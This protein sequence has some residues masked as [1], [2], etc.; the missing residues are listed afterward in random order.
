MNLRLPFTLLAL[1]AL[2]AFAGEPGPGPSDSAKA[3]L[4]STTGWSKDAF[5]PSPKSGKDILIPPPPQVRWILGG[6]V[7]LRHIGEIDFDSGV[8]P[9]TI[10]QLFAAGNTPVPGIGAP[11]G[12]VPRVYDNGY[13]GPDSRTPQIGRTTDY[14]YQD[15]GQIQADS[16]A[17]TATGGERREVTRTAG[18]TPA[19]WNE[20][21]EWNFSPYLKLSRLADRGNGWSLGPTFHF[22]YTNISGSRRG[23]NTQFGR[24]QLDI[25][26]VSATDTYDAT[27]LVLP[28]APY[29]GQPNIVAPLLPAEPANRTVDETLRQTDVALWNDSIR[30]SL[31]LD[32]WSFSL[33]A[34][35]VY[36]FE[37]RFF[38]TLGAGA[39]FNVGEWEA[40]RRDVL[41]QQVNNGAPIAVGSTKDRDYGLDVLWGLYA[42]AAAG[43]QVS[44]AFSLEANIRYDLT[45]SLSDTVGNSQFEVDLSGFTVGVGGNYTFW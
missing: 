44:D 36:Q 10:P 38:A 35:A 23:L 27:R 34:E 4:P 5:A 26:D 42:Q 13:V 11:T 24:E 28:N 43:Y 14:G 21:A 31:E 20:D 3:A 6:G 1:C 41:F 15:A 16:L 12:F 37:N 7:S 32:L 19:G 22:S 29:N 9:L 45:E 30:E 18:S 17:F 2:P 33:G 8:S 40:H 39:V 25:F